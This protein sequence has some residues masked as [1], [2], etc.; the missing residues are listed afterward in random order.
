MYSTG[1]LHP[2]KEPVRYSL[3]TGCQVFGLWC[4]PTSGSSLAPCLQSTHSKKAPNMIDRK[5][6]GSRHFCFFFL[7]VFFLS[8]LSSFSSAKPLTATEHTAHSS[9][10]KETVMPFKLNTTCADILQTKEVY[11]KPHSLNQTGRTME[12]NQFLDI[13]EHHFQ[14]ESYRCQSE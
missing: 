10:V 8:I 3:M 9:K 4:K 13:W 2:Y 14:M 12:F 6:T 11:Y 7:C 5:K 1:S